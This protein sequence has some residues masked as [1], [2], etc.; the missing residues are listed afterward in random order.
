MELGSRSD[1]SVHSTRVPS[2]GTGGC[3]SHWPMLWVG[4]VFVPTFCE[5]VEDWMPQKSLSGG[6]VA[7]V[8]WQ[9]AGARWEAQHSRVSAQV[10]WDRAATCLRLARECPPWDKRQSWGW[11]PSAETSSLSHSKTITPSSTKP[12]ELRGCDRNQCNPCWE[13]VTAESTDHSG[14]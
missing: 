9:L 5:A 3:G 10:S 6:Q 8:Q 11:L 2:A 7:A 13:N 1:H 4:R 14:R 12:S